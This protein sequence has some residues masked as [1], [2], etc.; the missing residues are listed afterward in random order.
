M[1]ANK[2]TETDKV[3][4]RALYAAMNIHRKVLNL[5]A[6]WTAFDPFGAVVYELHDMADE[7][8]N[9]REEVISRNDD[10]NYT[11]EPY[12]PLRPIKWEGNHYGTFKN[13]L[14][15]IEGAIRRFLRNPWIEK[16]LDNDE[17]ITV[18]IDKIRDSIRELRSQM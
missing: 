17:S 9:L 12:Y 2:A 14:K 7:A 5:V 16:G 18:T 1:K 6:M 13:H 11:K 8:W 3:Q 10:W 15:S 4:L